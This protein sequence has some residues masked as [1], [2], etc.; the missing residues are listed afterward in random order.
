MQR[1]HATALITF[2]I[3]GTLSV[4]A[5]EDLRPPASREAFHLFVLAGQSNM[6]GRGTVEPQDQE[7]HPRVLMLNKAGEWVPAVDPLHFDKPSIVG[8]GPGHSFARAW[9][10]S[11]PGVVVG[12]I[13]CAVG[14]SPI[15]AWRPGGFHASTKTHPWDDCMARVLPVLPAGTLR[16]ILWHQGESDAKSELAAV[17]ADRLDEV[18]DRFRTTLNAPCVPFIAGQMGQF[19]ERPWD[20]HKKT[21]D[22]AHE[23]LPHRKSNTAFVSS[24][25][26][27]HKGDEVHFDSASYRE[28]GTRYFAALRQLTCSG[29][30]RASVTARRP[31]KRVRKVFQNLRRVLPQQGLLRRPVR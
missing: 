5:Q 14:G 12:L 24:D 31:L 1:F 19:E 27:A 9:A 13:P 26:L 18:V 8:V 11:H 7:P 15:E 23:R 6:A 21:V 16:G 20:E 4:S 30:V 25:G 10:D 29:Q 3:V 28:L 17:Y 2:I 22:M